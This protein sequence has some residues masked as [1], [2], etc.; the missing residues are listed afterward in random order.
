[1]KRN[2]RSNAA[3]SS[4]TKTKQDA[5]KK[6]P[7]KP[8]TRPPAKRKSAAAAIPVHSEDSLTRCRWCTSDPE[9][10]TYHDEVWG[11]PLHDEHT[12]FE[13]LI[14]EGAQAGLNWLTILKRR[15]QYR[16]AFDNFDPAVVAKYDS[17]KVSNLLSQD[18]GIIRNK[19]K[20]A[21]A[22]S[23]ATAF[24]AVQKEFGSFDEYIWRFK[25]G[26]SETGEFVHRAT[27][28]ESVA[29]SADL[30]ERGFTFVGPTICYAFMQAVGM[31]TVHVSPANKKAEEIKP[32]HPTAA[33]IKPAFQFESSNF[34]IAEESCFDNVETLARHLERQVSTVQGV[35]FWSAQIVMS[36]SRFLQDSPSHKIEVEHYQTQQLLLLVSRNF[37]KVKKDEPALRFLHLP[38]LKGPEF[39]NGIR[40]TLQRVS[41]RE[42][43][44]S[45][46][47]YT[48]TVEDTETIQ[49]TEN[50][51]P[52]T[53]GIVSVLATGFVVGSPVYFLCVLLR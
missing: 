48:T 6:K 20:V 18:S 31:V 44:T 52:Y 4:L 53:S 22:I 9:Y 12:L 26:D 51:D 45:S 3:K 23:N 50:L 47:E 10:M 14:L 21:S 49:S 36:S 40:A 17:A 37:D 2:L 34:S 5:A 8:S 7:A 28:A 41:P 29:M 19:A 42:P 15:D 35:S 13:M 30:K 25:P 24:M 1:M 16:Q 43:A 27:S 33:L 32:D 46:Y 38:Q 39:R 11:V